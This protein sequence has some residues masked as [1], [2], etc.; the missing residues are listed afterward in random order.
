VA[1]GGDSA[2]QG[3]TLADVAAD[4][5]EGGTDFVAGEDFEK[6]FGDKV[7]GAVVVGKG[8]LF[9]SAG[10]DE[11]WPEDLGLGP[12]GGIGA[13]ACGCGGKEGDRGD[14]GGMRHRVALLSLSGTPLPPGG[15]LAGSPLE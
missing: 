15:I 11:D 12:E 2:N 7:I 6:A 13:S 1:A 8:D 3:G 5:E 4:H 9:G 10:G 14:G